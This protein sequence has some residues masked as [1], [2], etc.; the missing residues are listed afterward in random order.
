MLMKE[1]VIKCGVHFFFVVV[2]DPGI[3]KHIC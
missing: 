3:F 1:E 2:E